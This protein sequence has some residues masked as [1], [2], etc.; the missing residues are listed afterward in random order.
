MTINLA[1]NNPRIEYSVAQGVTQTVFAIPFEFFDDADLSV[2]VDGTLKAEG[3]DYTLS[4]GDGSTGTLT[5]VTATP[6]AVQQ[7]TGATG[8]SK[9]VI[10]RSTAIERTSD[11]S[12]GADI[13]RAALNEQLDILTAMVADAK[14]RT[15]RTIHLNQYDIAPSM[16]LPPISTLKGK[17]I[18]FDSTTGDIEA[19]PSV[20]DISVIASNI[21][22]ILQADDNATAAAASASAAASSAS[23]AS[24]SASS[25]SS[26]ASSASSSASSASTSASN[27]ASS[28]SAA[29]TSASNAATSASNAASSAS[30][31]ST[32]ASTAQ[33]AADAALAAL[34]SFDDRYLGQKASNPTLDNDGNAL[35]AGALYFNTTDSVMKVYTGSQWVAAYASL[36]GALLVNNNLSDLASASAA[37]TNL[38]LS[39]TA[40]QI[41]TLATIP[42]GLTGTELGYVDGVT[43]SIQTQIDGKQ[44]TITG[45]ATSITSSN[46]TANRA[47]ISDA[48]G[49]V[50]AS[51]V[52]NTEL[53]YAAY[54]VT[55]GVQTQLNNKQP[56]DATL[57]ALAAYS[58]NGL[59][60]Q[61]AADTFTGRSIAGTSNQITVTNGDGVS[62]NPT[63]S[64]VVASQAEAEAGT[65]TTKLMTPQRVSQAIT[66]LAQSGGMTLLG[67]LTTTSGS[68]QTLSGL[69]LTNY[70]QLIFEF[71]GV[72]HN[73]GTSQT[74]SVGSAQIAAGISAANL[75]YGIVN[76]SL[77]SGIS[78]AVL[79]RN[80]LPAVATEGYC[81]ASGYST[82]TTSVSVSVGGG[83][84]DAGSIRVYGMK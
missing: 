55:S 49:K 30:S 26:S 3:T 10:V 8:G 5:F 16:E 75:V 15:D 13:N 83:A 65:D 69:T 2:Y 70:K 29:S 18:A 33:T 42:A 38:G 50:A 84:F 80:T 9:V 63:I 58:T 72:S 45:G 34:D 41:N 17:T 36:S 27:A 35:V 12:A 37:L 59:L 79:S 28:A 54:G 22:E 43:S 66:A 4:G 68:T 60:T 23:S 82:A 53:A 11:F 81:G 32:S 46:L 52:S 39:A 21:T 51:I 24:S 74:I 48:N 57:T 61:T 25:A 67:T 73:S 40:A 31:A 64:A 6:P 1:N 19:G 71:N 44:A 62:G 56:L 47:L 7:V 20:Y 76:V 77:N 78:T 14:D